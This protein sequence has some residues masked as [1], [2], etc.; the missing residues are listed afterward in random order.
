MTFH[1]Q[2]GFVHDARMASLYLLDMNAGAEHAVDQ[3]WEVQEPSAQ[4]Q[5]HHRHRH[6]NIHFATADGRHNIKF[7]KTFSNWIITALIC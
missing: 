1:Y 3:L 2:V 7:M 4:P 5:H 6:H